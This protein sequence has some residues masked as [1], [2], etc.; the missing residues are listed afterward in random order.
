MQGALAKVRPRPLVLSVTKGQR[1]VHCGRSAEVLAVCSPTRVCLRIDGTGESVWAAAGELHSFV[2]AASPDRSTLGAVHASTPPDL[3]RET[4]WVRQFRDH[5]CDGVLSLED[6]DKIGK[7]MSRSSRTV[8]RHFTLYLEDQSASHQR[9]SKPGPVKGSLVLPSAVE[10]IIT[11]AIAEKYESAERP[12]TQA[13]V[14]HARM[15]A[16]AAGLR[17][18]SYTAVRARIERRDRWKAERRRHGR[19]RGNATAGPA[20]PPTVGLEP[21]DFVQMDHAIVDLIVVDPETRE[22]IGKPW[23]TLAIDVASRCVLGFYLTFDPPS[24]TSVALA[25]EMSCCPKDEWLSEAGYEDDWLPFGLMKVMG[26]DNAKCFKPT[27]LVQALKEYGIATRYRAVRNPTHGAHIERF[28]GT[29]MG[30]IHL[31]KG[32]TFS[33]TKERED[34]PSQKR[35]VMSLPEL[36]RW[37]ATQINGVYHNTPHRGLHGRT[38]LSVWNEAREKDGRY[39]MPTYPS[40]RRLFRL[41]MLPRV[42]RRVGREGLSRFRLHYWSEALTPLIRDRQ[43]YWVAHDPRD[44][45]VVYLLYGNEYLDIP[46]RDRTQPAV[47]LQEWERAKRHIRDKD[48]SYSELKAFESLARAREI[49]DDAERATRSARRNRARRPTGRRAVGPAETPA[50]KAIDYTQPSA[51]LPNP[52]EFQP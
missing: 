3:E 45:S 27:S 36:I 13:V 48:G 46:W 7:S 31:L 29:Y 1:V 16:R 43:R 51:V 38:P 14:E 8:D 12:S 34:Y 20:G 2:H 30:K 26:W 5:E 35:A 11:K 21:L 10:A 19:V 33:N 25:T 6:R 41:S 24:Q 40:D 23:I 39:V 42:L 37:T 50:A 17:A 22:E 28:I 44:I 47:S 18:P 15:L 4:E 49:E 32:T 52:L 9:P